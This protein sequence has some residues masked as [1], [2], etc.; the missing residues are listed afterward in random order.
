[1]PEMTRQQNVALNAAKLRIKDGATRL[2]RL[3]PMLPDEQNSNGTRQP[4]LRFV[5]E[6]STPARLDDVRVVVRRVLGCPGEP[7]LPKGVSWSKGSLTVTDELVIPNLRVGETFDVRFLFPSADPRDQR[8]KLANFVVVTLPIDSLTAKRE[9]GSVHIDPT[10]GKQFGGGDGCLY[11]LAYAIRSEGKFMRVDPEIPFKWPSSQQSSQ[12]PIDHAWNH[13]NINM[14]PMDTPLA[15]LVK[16]GKGIRV[17]Q[18]DTGTG[19]HPECANIYAPVAQHGCTIDGDDNSVDPLSQFPFDNPGHGISTASVLAS[20]GSVERF[21]NGSIGTTN[22]LGGTNAPNHEVT[23]IANKCTV[24]PVRAVSSVANVLGINIA[25]GVW[26]C[27]QQ[28][29]HVITMSIGCLGDSWLERVISYA[30]FNNIIVVGAAGQYIPWVPAPAV[31]DDCIAATASTSSDVVM[32]SPPATKGP[33][34]DIGA[35]GFQIYCAAADQRRGNYVGAYPGTSFSAPTVAGAAALWL[36]KHGRELLIRSYD[37]DGRGLKLA[38]VFRYLIRMTARVPSDWNTNESGAGIIDVTALLN[39]P[40]PAAGSVPRKNWERYNETTQKQI[41]K[42]QLGNPQEN[43]FLAALAKFLN[44]TVAEISTRLQEFGSEVLKLIQT[45]TD[46]FERLKTAVETAVETAASGVQEA[47]Q[48]AIKRVVDEIRDAC[49]V[50][51]SIVMG[52]FA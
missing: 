47:V 25:E 24:V 19:N 39:A 50:T 48:E 18:V 33:A 29:V 27:I 17:G 16:G 15:K 23:G 35:P 1:M 22:P 5:I 8:F 31:Y 11:D 13:R 14:P 32:A 4:N 7:L 6:T 52:W 9:L 2:G 36:V 44:S 28:G 41:L 37:S 3:T 26:H 30:V 45:T 46:A 12:A 43:P 20:R 34:I 51:V 38:E 21:N 40:L 10:T 42:T 49:S